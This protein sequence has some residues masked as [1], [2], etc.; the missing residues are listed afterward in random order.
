MAFAYTGVSFL[1]S[2]LLFQIELMIAKLLLPMY[3]GSFHV[4]TTCM[5]FFTGMLLLGYLYADR[6]MNLA[7]QR[8]YAMLHIVFLGAAALGFPISV[9]PSNS[10]LPPLVDILLVLCRSISLPF[11]ALSVTS[12]LVQKW[13][14]L[15]MSNDNKNPY[16]LYAASNAGA[17]AALLSYPTVFEPLFTVNQQ[18]TIWY[19]LY[20]VFIL[21]HFFC[22]PKQKLQISPRVYPTSAGKSKR[23]FSWK[24]PVY[25]TLTSAGTCALML[26][27]TNIITLDIAAVPL[28]WMFP[29]A[30]YLATII[31]N[32]KQKPWYPAYLNIVCLLLASGLAI[33]VFRHPAKMF[34]KWLILF[35]CLVLFMGCMV[36]HKNLY[37][38]KP[39]AP[40]LLGR[41]YVSIGAGGWFAAFVIGVVIPLL[42]RHFPMIMVDY[43]LAFLL[44]AGS[45]VFR[46]A[47]GIAAFFS[48]RKVVSMMAVTCFLFIIGT[49]IVAMVRTE[50]KNLLFSVRNFYGIWKVS[51]QK[52]FNVLFHGNTIHGT[53]YVDPKKQSIPLTYF[54]GGSPVADLFKLGMEYKRVGVIGL[55]VGSLTAYSRPGEAWDIYEIDP[56]VVKIAKQFF[57]FLDISPV[58]PNII[59]GDARLSL[60]RADP[61]VYDLFIIDAF[62][63]D[64]IPMHLL[65]REALEIYLNKLTADGILV[66]HISNRYLNLKGAL[67]DLAESRQIAACF[68]IVMDVDA[69]KGESGSE[70]LVMSRDSAKIARFISEYGWE[71]AR[72]EIKLPRRRP[73]SDQYVNIIPALLAK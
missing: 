42:G 20:V 1:A 12:P 36:G 31:V 34:S 29:L 44:V 43:M 59:L 55:G 17:L 28:L 67:R 7:N 68:K 10:G 38:S 5:M 25:W 46:D 14:S 41:Y 23:N 73:W 24:G 72:T 26:A 30:I 19:A 15:S 4:W 51:K 50:N 40:N 6:A 57:T 35:H 45:L 62:S 27:V 21:C 56:D 52:D 64:S 60:G 70:W 61:A 32:F 37:N 65:T 2:F 54:H 49:G 63:S 58:K 3:G 16:F 48:R 33:F 22:V 71:D 69:E 66:F 13:F 8:F 47:E 11:F 9:H 53:Q 18:L 39:A